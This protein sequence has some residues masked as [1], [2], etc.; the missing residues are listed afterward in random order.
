MPLPHGYVYCY[1]CGGYG[2]EEAPYPENRYTC[3]R[4]CETGILKLSELTEEERKFYNEEESKD[5]DHV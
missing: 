4:C 5:S 3:Y 2:S 1:K